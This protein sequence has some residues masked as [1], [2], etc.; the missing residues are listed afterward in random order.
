MIIKEYLDDRQELTGLWQSREYQSES[1]TFVRSNWC[2]G[3]RKRD[4]LSV[5]QPT[6]FARDFINEKGRSPNPNAANSK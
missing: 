1:K 2:P 5:K 4:I 3:W 6:S